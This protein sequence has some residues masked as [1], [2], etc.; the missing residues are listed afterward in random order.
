MG[1]LPLGSNVAAYLRHTSHVLWLMIH[2]IL[3]L[4]LSLM[5]GL[6]KGLLKSAVAVTVISFCDATGGEESSGPKCSIFE[7]ANVVF[8]SWLIAFSAWVAWKKPE[9]AP[10]IRGTSTRPIPADPDA[11]TPK[12][13]ANMKKWDELNIQLYGAVVSHVSAPI[14]SSLHVATPDDGVAAINHLKQRYGARSTGDRAEAMARVQRSY[15]DPRAKISEADVTKQYNE[16]SLA[17]ADVQA[18]G[19]AAVDD[20]LLISMFENSLPIAYASIRQMVRYQSHTV[21]DTYFNDL[22][23]QVKAEERSAQSAVATAFYSQSYGGGKGRGAKGKGGKGQPNAGK[24]GKG[25]GKGYGGGWN[26][27]YSPCFNCGKTDHARYSCPEPQTYCEYCG[28]NHVSE[29]CSLGPGGPLRD[30]L[31]V[32]ARM[33]IDRATG[34]GR[35]SRPALHLTMSTDDQYTESTMNNSATSQARAYNASRKRPA[36]TLS[37]DVGPHDSASNVGSSVGD[38]SMAAP[39]RQP[40]PGGGRAYQTNHRSVPTTQEIDDYIRS[41]G[42][43]A[44]MMHTATG[45]ATD[46]SLEGEPLHL[47]A[48]IDS[49]ASYFAVPDASYLSKVTNWSPRVPIETAS[50]VIMPDAIGELVISLCDDN[51]S[52]HTFTIQETWVLKSCN[53]LLYSQGAMNRL[54]VMHRLDEGYL[55]LPGGSKKTISRDLYSVDLILGYPDTPCLAS[56]QLATS[57]N[58]SPSL[59][60]ARSPVPQR[61]LWQRLGCPGKQVWL[62]VSDVMT[63]HGLPPN[64][65]LRYDFE[66]TDAVTRA[67]SRVLPFHR[68][69]D[70]DPLHVPGSTVYMDFAGPMVA[71]YPHKF[72]YYC[73]AIDAGS[74]YARLVPCHSA[75]KEVAKACLELLTADI[76]A[77]MGLTHR[78]LPHVVVSDQGSQFMSEYFRDFLAD[79]QVVHRPAVTYTPQQNSFVERMW[80]TR[81]AIARTLLKAANLGP[82]FHPFAVQT[83]NWICNRIPQPWRSNLSAYF[84]LSKRLASA[85]YLKVFGS[86][87]H[88]TLP[89]AIGQSEK[90]TNTLQTVVFWVYI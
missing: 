24:G 7:G 14:Q 66:T 52:W 35:S 13:R 45:Y 3:V 33:A 42:Y 40:G 89:W 47:M 22:L 25:R 19:G 37:N 2:T 58:D 28:A 82:T 51:G 30:A 44:F 27:T 87:S 18:T 79:E 36:S 63:D 6:P 20:M 38:S 8:M 34:K 5:L 62:G 59:R 86:L 69:R 68:I 1:G 57:S 74:G 12:E 32:N 10:F 53:K 21:F 73:G 17:V 41:A 60:V 84:I 81:F 56:A 31:S 50:G 80:G 70:P 88:M 67:R 78:F 64:P 55:I 77:L 11:P 29:M 72:I 83:S 71:S 4:F 85:A 43:G 61:L 75:T 23:T 9:L 48:Y 49:Q 54:G 26:Q 90:E 39:Q 15:I 65:H 76:R 46:S 16:M